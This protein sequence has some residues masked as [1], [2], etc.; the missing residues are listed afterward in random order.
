MKGLFV[1][2]ITLACFA[3][4]DE[5]YDLQTI[6]LQKNLDLVRAIRSHFRYDIHHGIYTHHSFPRRL[7]HHHCGVRGCSCIFTTVDEAEDEIDAIANEVRAIEMR[8]KGRPVRKCGKGK[9]GWEREL[10]GRLS[11]CNH[12]EKIKFRTSPLSRRLIAEQKA[13]R[14]M[15]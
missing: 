9:I 5:E 7:H 6:N 14:R 10:R 3:R 1:L 8:E 13:I 4:E 15:K 11:A 2:M 12:C